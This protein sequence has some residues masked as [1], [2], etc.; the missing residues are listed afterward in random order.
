MKSMIA[1][2]LVVLQASDDLAA[3]VWLAMA[4]EAGA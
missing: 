1:S 2:A 4:V 3:N